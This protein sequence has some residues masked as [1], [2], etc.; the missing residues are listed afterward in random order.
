MKAFWQS[1]ACALA[2]AIARRECSVRDVVDA[3]LARIDEVNPKVNA[4]VRVLRDEA[5][6]AAGLADQALDRG[7]A[8]GP[9][10]GVPFPSSTGL[11]SSTPRSTHGSRSCAGAA[12]RLPVRFFSSSAEVMW[13]AWMCVSSVQA[14]RRPSSRSTRRSRSISFITGSISTAW[15]LSLQASRYV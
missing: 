14:R 9:L 1:T 4:I 15:P 12:M 2:S 8:L 5:R 10:H 7:D 3:H 13:S 6:A 11:P